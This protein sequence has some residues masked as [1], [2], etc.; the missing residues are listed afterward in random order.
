MNNYL[1]ENPDK[2]RHRQLISPICVG[3]FRRWRISLQLSR[4][5]SISAGSTFSLSIPS[6][7]RSLPKHDFPTAGQRTSE[8][9]FSRI[10]QKLLELINIHRRIDSHRPNYLNTFVSSDWQNSRAG[11]VTNNARAFRSMSEHFTTRF[12]RPGVEFRPLNFNGRNSVTNDAAM[13]AK[14]AVMH[15]RETYSTPAACPNT[16]ES[17]FFRKNAPFFLNCNE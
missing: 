15:C 7:S 2:Q 14:D 12:R 13:C 6:R 17:T 1:I 11:E 5:N 3:L 8:K 4:S 16:I 9:R 10:H